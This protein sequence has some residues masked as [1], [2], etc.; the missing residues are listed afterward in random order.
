MLAHGFSSAL[1]RE[2]ITE[3]RRQA[4]HARLARAA[5]PRRTRRQRHASWD[6]PAPAGSRQPLP[7]TQAGA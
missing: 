4:D 1:A 3:L 2:R 5:R 6:H 7:N